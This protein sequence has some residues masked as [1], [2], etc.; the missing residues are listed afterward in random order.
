MAACG[1]VASRFPASR[2]E[3]L[4][5]DGRYQTTCALLG[6]RAPARMCTSG[7]ESFSRNELSQSCLKLLR[8]GKKSRVAPLLSRK[9]PPGKDAAG[10]SQARTTEQNLAKAGEE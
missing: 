4:A 7:F 8:D 2:H 9:Q 1:P 5:I 6:H 3:S 10:N